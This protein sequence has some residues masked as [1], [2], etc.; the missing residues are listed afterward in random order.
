MTSSPLPDNDPSQPDF[1]ELPS[2]PAA[3]AGPGSPVYPDS[4]AYPGYPTYPGYPAQSGY[5]VQPGYPYQANY[6]YQSGP[7]RFPNAPTIAA[8]AGPVWHRPRPV[9]LA[10][11]LSLVGAGLLF[12]CGVLAQLMDAPSAYPDGGAGT[13]V[14]VLVLWGVCAGVWVGLAALLWHGFNWARVVFTVLSP[15]CMV[16]EVLLAT[17]ELA[18]PPENAGG[19]LTGLLDFATI[20]VAVIALV[21]V[22][23]PYAQDFYSLRRARRRTP[24]YR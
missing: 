3:P 16:M 12:L 17:G 7:F 11:L 1:S 5:P 9:Q 19:V 23:H 2:Y 13:I 10:V 4:P 14:G 18:G 22:Y 21:A 20:L 6:P 8:E 24:Y 15:I